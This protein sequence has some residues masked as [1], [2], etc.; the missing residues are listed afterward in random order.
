MGGVTL[1]G[2]GYYWEWTLRFQKPMT[3][4]LVLVSPC[5]QFLCLSSFLQ[6]VGEEYTSNSC[7]SIMS[8]SCG[9]LC[10]DGLELKLQN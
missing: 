7:S 2:E 4:P 1:V 10:C 6:L 9:V 3:G 8:A 5:P